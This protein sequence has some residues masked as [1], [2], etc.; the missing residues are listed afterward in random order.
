MFHKDALAQ[1]L[2][3]HMEAGLKG[4]H[5]AAGELIDPTLCVSA[6]TGSAAVPVGAV[7]GRDVTGESI[8]AA[9]KAQTSG[10]IG[11]TRREAGLRRHHRI[12]VVLS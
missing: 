3:R 9:M 5:G 7:K 6:I 2:D 4:R 12:V 8:D 1:V 11:C 10:S